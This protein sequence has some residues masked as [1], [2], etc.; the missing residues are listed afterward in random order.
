MIL[1]LR[2]PL[3]L[4]EM[5]SCLCSW[6]GIHTSGK[7]NHANIC[8]VGTVIVRS[9]SSELLF[10]TTYRN[11]E[12]ECQAAAHLNTGRKCHLWKG[13]AIKN[14]LGIRPKEFSFDSQIAK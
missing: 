1:P 8:K 4:F 12:R 2:V 11:S 5:K 13:V 9:L 14:I 7:I 3:H 6:L 10:T